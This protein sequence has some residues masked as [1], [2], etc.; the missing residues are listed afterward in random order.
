MKHYIPLIAGLTIASL[1]MTATPAEAQF[2]NLKK[3]RQK[4]SRERS[5]KRS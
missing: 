3:N 2:K 1:M 4:R 5:Q